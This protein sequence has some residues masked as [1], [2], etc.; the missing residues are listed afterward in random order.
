MKTLQFYV[1]C[2]GERWQL[3]T[4]ERRGDW[5][6]FPHGDPLFAACLTQA[7][8]AGPAFLA[9]AGEASGVLIVLR[10]PGGSSAQ[11]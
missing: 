3:A 1:R 10:V 11:D 6:R 7:L 4:F 2:R 8:A 9:R 5:V